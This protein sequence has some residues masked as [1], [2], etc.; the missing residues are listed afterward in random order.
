MFAVSD[1]G[2]VNV[3]FV[4][5]RRAGYTLFGFMIYTDA[6]RAMVDYMKDGII[7]I[8]YLIDDRSCA[9][10]AIESPSEKWIAYSRKKS[11]VA[12][13]QV[14]WRLSGKELEKE[15][16]EEKREAGK[17]L[18]RRFR[19]WLGFGSRSKFEGINMNNIQSSVI[20]VGDNQTVTVG[21]LTDPDYNL[22]NRAEAYDVAKHFN[23]RRTDVPCIVFFHDW[24][25]KMIWNARLGGLDTQEKLNAFF[26]DFFENDFDKLAK[27]P[28]N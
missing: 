5:L 11:S 24:D 8:D 23:L 13:Y 27:Q 19:N 9:I 3:A 21:S 7:D 2:K 28:L 1:I 18:L 22:I 4:E 10:F 26:R 20:V 25:G 16:D 6:D 17:T 15:P 12:E 14:W